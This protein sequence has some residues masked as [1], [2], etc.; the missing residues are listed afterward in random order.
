MRVNIYYLFLIVFCTACSK[1]FLDRT[2]QSYSS[3]HMAYSD[4]NSVKAALVGC[5]DGLQ[6]PY[7]YGR[8]FMI[9]PEIYSDNAKL[10]T[11]NTNYYVSFYNYSVTS[12]EPMLDGLWKIG[13]QIIARANNIIHSQPLQKPSSVYTKQILG[14]ALAIRA[15]VY[16]DLVRTFAQTYTLKSGV[17]G[18]DGNGGHTGIPII[19]QETSQD[20]IISPP[21]N[22]VKS[23]YCQIISD[24][25]HAEKLMNITPLVPCTFSKLSAEALLAR[26]YLTKEDWDSAAMYSRKLIDSKSYSLVSNSN[27]V[28]SWSEDYTS[29]SILSV[30]TLLN[31][32][33]VTNA[34]GYMLSQSGYADIVATNDLY[35]LYTSSDNRKTLFV[36]GNASNIYIN[37]YPGRSS[38]IGLDNVPIL[39]YSEMY[40]IQA[41]AIYHRNNQDSARALLDSIVKRA[42]NVYIPIQASNGDLLNLIYTERRK[43]L[44]FEGQRFFDIKRQQS[45][46]SR[47]DC[48]ASVCSV[49]YPSNL[50][51]LPIPISEI[52]AN[53]N[54]IQN[55]GY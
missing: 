30:A 21:R 45:G 7:Y 53:K 41:E 46:I 26:V 54:I 55:P 24:L 1:S 25:L 28:P 51:A 2:P 42:D 6:D 32:Y 39:R 37:K 44:A 27:Y 16:F 38:V 22:T 8:N 23:V 34:L 31:D 11:N 18:A 14:E 50:F 9:I 4:S 43:E 12:S 19:T 35:S 36:E 13:Y 15:L 47:N 48:N 49:P 20:S 40:L 17:D 33:N 29:E 3:K 52:N 10:A 5:Y